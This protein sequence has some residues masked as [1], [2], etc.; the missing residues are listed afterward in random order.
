V[1]ALRRAAVAQNIASSNGRSSLTISAKPVGA[2][3]GSQP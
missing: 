3:G 1:I 2:W